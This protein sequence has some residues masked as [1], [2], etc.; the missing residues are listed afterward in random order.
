MIYSRKWFFMKNQGKIIKNRQCF[1]KIWNLD[2]SFSDISPP[3]KKQIRSKYL[4]VWKI[5]SNL[6]NLGFLWVYKQIC[7]KTS[8]Q[9]WVKMMKNAARGQKNVIFSRPHG[10][11][12]KRSMWNVGLKLHTH[13]NMVIIW[14]FIPE[15]TLD[16]PSENPPAKRPV[17]FYL[18]GVALLDILR[19]EVKATRP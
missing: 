13:F 4:A 6:S 12:Q 15:W 18:K 10:G 3:C 1:R 5:W 16:C 14:G 8:K 19:L 17:A 9:R 2:H 11:R 7:T